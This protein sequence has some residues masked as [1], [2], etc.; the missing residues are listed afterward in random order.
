MIDPNNP[1]FSL[2]ERTC[3]KWSLAVLYALDSLPD[4]GTTLRNR[5]L[6]NSIVG[7]PEKSLTAALKKL[8]EDGL[9]N[10]QFIPMKKSAQEGRSY[11]F[12]PDTFQRTDYCLTPKGRELMVIIKKLEAWADVHPTTDK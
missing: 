4:D 6:K 12:E 2:I 8:E 3:K 5:D 10:R 9:I 11:R 1:A 7:I